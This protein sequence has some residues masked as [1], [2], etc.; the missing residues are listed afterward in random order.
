MG[1]RLQGYGCWRGLAPASPHFLSNG[2][3]QCLPPRTLQ[4][5]CGIEV[6][7]RCFFLVYFLVR[8]V[9]QRMAAA[10][11]YRGVFCAPLISEEQ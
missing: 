10:S 9:Q 1:K 7:D 4:S 2:K 11:F 8:L 3:E 5:L 6:G